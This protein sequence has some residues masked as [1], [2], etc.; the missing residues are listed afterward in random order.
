MLAI[1]HRETASHLQFLIANYPVL[2]GDCG[3]L[4]IFKILSDC[5]VRFT[6]PHDTT[7]QFLRDEEAKGRKSQISR[8]MES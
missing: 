1:L 4:I 2:A 7:E 8:R 3:N 6:P 5:L